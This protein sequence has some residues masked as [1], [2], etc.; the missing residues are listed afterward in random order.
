MFVA[1]FHSMFGR[2]EVELAAAE[3]LRTAGHDVV[4][5]DLFA[6]E[7]VPGDIDQG[8][9][10]MKTIGWEPIVDRARRS[11]ST[12]PPDAVLGGFSMG[13]GVV[14]A[15]WPERPDAAGAFCLHAPLVVP[16][17]A[18]AGTPVQVHVGTADPFAPADQL[19]RFRESA[20]AAGAVASVHEYPH[21]GHFFTDV[22]LSDYDEAA[23][24]N[25][26]EQVLRLLEEIGR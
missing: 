21:V 12:A 1:L 10:L 19:V 14:G 15:L 3:R 25:T 17:T 16:R 8:W 18:R 26:W 2:R 23:A 5:P 20:V 6:G 7:T 9:A 13:V 4:V 24:V 22:T 11:L